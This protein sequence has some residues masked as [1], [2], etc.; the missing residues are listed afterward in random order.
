MEHPADRR[1]RRAHRIGN[2]H[3]R[4]LD[5]TAD[6]RRIQPGASDMPFPVERPPERQVILPNPGG[7]QHLIEEVIAYLRRQ[8]PRSRQRHHHRAGPLGN[9]LAV[10]DPL[11]HVLDHPAGDARTLARKLGCH[12]L[13]DQHPIQLDDKPADLGL[14]H[15]AVTE[16]GKQGQRQRVA[17]DM[18]RRTVAMF[19]LT[20]TIAYG[21]VLAIGCHGGADSMRSA[22]KSAMPSRTPG[23][24]GPITADTRRL[25][26]RESGSLLR[27]DT[28]PLCHRS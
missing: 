26:G 7:R 21:L 3:H 5:R 14:H 8:K 10:V 27:P 24:C 22:A 2:Q 19:K 23:G 25:F 28:A 12:H 16:L 1:S 18:H 13:V 6:L 20:G 9:H 17:Q 11:R 4:V 15:V